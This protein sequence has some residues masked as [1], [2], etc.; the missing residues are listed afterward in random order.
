MAQR[1]RLQGHATPLD[2]ADLVI[3]LLRCWEGQRL[4]GRE[5]MPAMTQM[6]DGCGYDLTLVPICDSL[7]ALTESCVGRPLRCGAVCAARELPFGAYSDDE[8][9]LLAMLS[10]SASISGTQ[11]PPAIPHGLP[12]VLCWA[13]RALLR[14][15][16]PDEVTLETRLGDHCPFVSS[17]D[18]SGLAA[19]SAGSIMH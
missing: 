6:V 5:P 17:R 9:G 4:K 18:R 10:E 8:L 1:H 14:V 16:G 11:A 7:F 3:A 19:P 2:G 12:G 13:A 15:L